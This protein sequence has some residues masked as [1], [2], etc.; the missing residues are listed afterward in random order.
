MYFESVTGY[1]LQIY[2][3]ELYLLVGYFVRVLLAV[4]T[5]AGLTPIDIV[6]EQVCP[7]CVFTNYMFVPLFGSRF[8]KHFKLLSTYLI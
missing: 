4:A 2:G 3:P 1:W 6:V 7:S 5:D 8:F